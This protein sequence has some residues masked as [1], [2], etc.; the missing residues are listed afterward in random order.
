MRAL[1]I[2]LL[3]ATALHTVAAAQLAAPN[4]QGVAIGH[5]HVFTTD[6]AAQSRFWTTLGGKITQ[7]GKL[8]LAEFPG[9]YLVLEPQHPSGGTVGTTLNHFGFWVK[10]F[11][12]SVARW[13]AAGLP[14]EPVTTNPAQGQGFI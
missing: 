10:D 5:V 14:W 11:D 13:K 3:A 6:V 8:T 4:A 2:G 1:A 12:A 9:I 7:R